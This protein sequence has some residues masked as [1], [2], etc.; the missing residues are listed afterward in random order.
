MSNKNVIV[1]LCDQLRADFLSCYGFEGIRTP[2]IDAI[3]SEGVRFEHAVTASPVCA[4]ARASM[5]TGRYVSD[6]GVWTNDMPF[7][8]GME[9]LPKRVNALGYRTGCF[10]KLHHFPAA[11]AKGFQTVCLMEENRLKE[12]E[13]YLLWLKQ[14]GKDAEDVFPIEDGKF[15]FEREFYYESWIA[16]QAMEFIEKEASPF[17]AW[18]SFQGPHTPLDPVKEVKYEEQ[19]LSFQFHRDYKPACEV[20]NYRKQRLDGHFTDQDNIEYRE[21]YCNLIQELDF[22]IGRLRKFLKHIGQYDDT[23]IVF[24]ADHGDLCGDYGMRQKGPYLYSA[25]LEI[26][27]IVAHHPELPKSVSSDILT[28]N[29]DIAATVLEFMGD[30]RPFGFSRDIATMYLKPE[31]QRDLVYSEFCD[32]VKIITSHEFR[33]A[34]YPFTGEHELIRLNREMIPLH[35]EQEY[36]NVVIRMLQQIIDFQVLSKGVNIEA[37]DLTPL[38]QKGLSRKLPNYMEI[39]PL[40]FPIQ[41]KQQIQNLAEAGLDTAYNEFCKNKNIIRSYGAYWDEFC[42]TY[43]EGETP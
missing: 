1:I 9:Y 19:N 8:S 28:G 39:I 11:D 3:A 38:V 12:K 40:A 14:Q 2:N 37:Q 24:S 23:L 33:F 27:L 20:A 15:P 5:M 30:D 6:H 21:K 31:F 17:F 4:P 26:P 34:Y 18:I 42:F 32:S 29:L 35:E 41:S 22:Q 13:D 25:Q 7:R 36:Q 16:E 43:S 10:G